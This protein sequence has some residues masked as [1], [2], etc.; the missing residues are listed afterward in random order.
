MDT[1]E[2]DLALA[3]WL[4]SNHMTSMSIAWPMKSSS[5]SQMQE[6]GDV[7]SL[8]CSWLEKKTTPALSR[9]PE[10]RTS[11]DTLSK[12]FRDLKGGLKALRAVI[13][14]SDLDVLGM[15]HLLWKNGQGACAPNP[16]RCTPAILRYFRAASSKVGRYPDKRND[17][18]AKVATRQYRLNF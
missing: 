11:S 18:F 16:C 2:K 7:R 5:G 8:C 10:Y 4:R 9:P 17:D 13:I 1:H 14:G 6:F 15:P 12:C 3:K